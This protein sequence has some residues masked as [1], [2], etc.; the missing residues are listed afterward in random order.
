M[1]GEGLATISTPHANTRSFF[2]VVAVTLM[3][4]GGVGPAGPEGPERPQGP[5]GNANVKSK[6]F[7]NLPFVRNSVAMV[8]EVFLD[9]PE[10]T[11]DIIRNGSVQVFIT[12]AND[13]SASWTSLPGSFSPDVPAVAPI[14]LDV[15]S[16][17]GRVA[18]Y[19]TDTLTFMRADYRVV[20]TAAS[21]APETLLAAPNRA[22]VDQG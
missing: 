6:T 22:Q 4:C 1:R 11:T 5:P 10:V 20:V 15:Q 3:S 8:D 14:R 17:Q 12:P 13:M 7:T 9:W 18:V 16:T 21:T 2:I 19:T